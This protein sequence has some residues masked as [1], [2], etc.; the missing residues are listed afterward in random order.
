MVR[1]KSLLQHMHNQFM[2]VAI[3]V[4]NTPCMPQKMTEVQKYCPFMVQSTQFKYKMLYKVYFI[5]KSNLIGSTTFRK[6]RESLVYL[7]G[8]HLG[9]YWELISPLLL[10]FLNCVKNV[11][12]TSFMGW[13]NK[14]IFYCIDKHNSLR[15]CLL[16]LRL[17][18]LLSIF[19]YKSLI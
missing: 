11:L 4:S 18:K 9:K 12:K 15:F 17:N 6:K 3:K 5:L 19:N 14:I 16:R 8:V 13:S 10:F 1:I 7:R 2:C